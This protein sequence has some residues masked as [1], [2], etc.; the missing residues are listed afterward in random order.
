V[1]SSF[2]LLHLLVNGKAQPPAPFTPFLIPHP[3]QSPPPPPG[4]PLRLLFMDSTLQEN[5]EG[6]L[7]HFIHKCYDTKLEEDLSQHPLLGAY[8]GRGVHPCT[9]SALIHHPER[10]WFIKARGQTLAIG[11][12]IVNWLQAPDEPEARCMCNWY[13]ARIELEL[14]QHVLLECPLFNDVAA[15]LRQGHCWK[16][17]WSATSGSPRQ[18]WEHW[19]RLWKGNKC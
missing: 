6:W 2:P 8:F 1:E 13:Q 11:V 12:N 9:W 17:P 3:F 4:A 16:R 14:L 15:P 18:T 19:L 5:R 10:S 7:S